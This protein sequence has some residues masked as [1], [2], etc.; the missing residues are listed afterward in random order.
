MGMLSKENIHKL[1]LLIS[2]GLIMYGIVLGLTGRGQIQLLP[3]IA[4][5]GQFYFRALKTFTYEQLAFG[6]WLPDYVGVRQIQ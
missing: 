6:C 3:G 1:Y 2:A 5:D 4:G